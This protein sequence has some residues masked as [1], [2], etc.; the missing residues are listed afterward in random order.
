MRG[1]KT[2]LDRIII[3][4]DTDARG[5]LRLQPFNFI[6]LISWLWR[7]LINR[8]IIFKTQPQAQY[9]VVERFKFTISIV[10]ISI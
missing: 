10:E 6:S 2:T 9:E 1:L 8:L 4:F 7:A 3:N 5:F